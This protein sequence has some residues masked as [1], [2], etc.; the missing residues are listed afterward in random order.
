MKERTD[1]R[2][3]NH[4]GIATTQIPSWRSATIKEAIRIT[5]KIFQAVSGFVRPGRTEK[6][7]AD[8]M[9]RRSQKAGLDL[10]WEPSSCPAVFTGPDTAAAHYAPTGRVVERGH[11]LNMDFGLRYNGYCSDLQRTFY[12]LKHGEHQAPPD[13]Q[14]GFDTIVRS[15]EASRRKLGPGGPGN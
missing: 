12:I 6:E 15:I 11:V 14:N 13:V 3:A 2:R 8:F 4:L 9:K 5:E 1:L 7:I 10:A